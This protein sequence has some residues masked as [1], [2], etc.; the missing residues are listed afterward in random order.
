MEGR[1]PVWLKTEHSYPNPAAWE[2]SWKSLDEVLVGSGY[3]AGETL[4]MAYRLKAEDADMGTFLVAN[5]LLSEEDYCE[6]A[7]LCSGAAARP[8]YVDPALVNPR[9]AR[10]M[11]IRLQSKCRITPI[12]IGAWQL[13]LATP[14]A[15]SADVMAELQR[16]T[17]L[18]VQFRLV[19]P[20]NYAE[21]RSV[22]FGENTELA[23]VPRAKAGGQRAL[24]AAV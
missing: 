11:P 10:S 9:A 14:R 3:L 20:S 17:R 8:F 6:A 12:L 4:A 7:S 19:T 16:H 1:A 5:G 24:A 15:P 13:Y 18:Q 2:A 21:I 23:L 22:L